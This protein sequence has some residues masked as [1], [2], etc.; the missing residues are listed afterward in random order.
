MKEILITSS[1]LIGVLMLLRLMFAQKVSRKLIYGAWILVALRLLIPVQI[2][3]LDFSVLTA[4]RPLTE[5]V[6]EVSGLRVMG[7]NEREA[8][9]Q[10]TKDYIEQDRTVF[11]PEVQEYIE[12]AIEKNE[13]PEQIATA[14]IKTQGREEI[15][16]EHVQAQVALQVQEQTDFVSLGQAA[17]ILWL[18]GLGVMTL[19]F[20]VV[21]LRHSRNLRK[22]RNKLETDSPIPVY[23]SDAASSPCLVG[24]VRPAVYL[25]PASVAD[26]KMLEHV[27]KHELTHYRHGDHIWAL[28]RGL[29]L[30]IYWFDPLVWAAAY[31]SRRDCELACDEG[32]MRGMDAAERVSYGKTL[33]EV[34]SQ[35]AGPV[36][37][38]QTA[39]SMN[40]N[41]KQLK[42][43]VCFIVKKPKLSITA[44]VCMV[45]L[46]AIVAGCAAA[47]ASA[48]QPPQN[49]TTTTPTAPTS[50]TN[51]DQPSTRIKLNKQMNVWY[52]SPDAHLQCH[53]LVCKDSF[54]LG[55]TI[56]LTLHIK[57]LGKAIAYTGAL[58]DQIGSI[59]LWA[60]NGE[61]VIQAD[62][63]PNTDDV[64]PQEF[65]HNE[66]A[67]LVYQ[68][69]VPDSAQ[70]DSYTLEITAFGQQIRFDREALVEKRYIPRVADLSEEAQRIIAREEYDA[71]SF[72]KRSNTTPVYGEFGDVYVAFWHFTPYGHE[73]SST[74]EEVNGLTFEYINECHIEVYA[75]GG[76]YSLTEA[77]ASGLL[78]TEQIRQVYDNY[79]RVGPQLPD[80][81]PYIKVRAWQAISVLG[82]KRLHFYI[83]G[84]SH[85]EFYVGD[86][87]SFKVIVTNQD[88]KTSIESITDSVSKTAWLVTDQS[89][90][91]IETDSWTMVNSGPNGEYLLPG[92]SIEMLITFTVPEDIQKD[93]RYNLKILVDDTELLFDEY[94]TIFTETD[95]I[96]AGKYG[97]ILG[98]LP[99]DEARFIQSYHPHIPEF[100]GHM[101]MFEYYSYS[102][103]H[104]EPYNI[105]IYLYP[106]GNADETPIAETVCGKEFIYPPGYRIYVVSEKHGCFTLTEAVEAGIVSIIEIRPVHE[107][108][109]TR[110]KHFVIP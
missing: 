21:N 110:Q 75:P 44:A 105:Y 43:R 103:M 81:T 29:C 1:V 15:Y 82:Q 51:A 89:N 66:E 32:A 3:Q 71:P 46:C 95:T 65:R 55:E 64:T 12:S 17:K 7:Q 13:T 72:T 2:G 39:T 99:E 47:G 97:G 19:W 22:N 45:L 83:E 8:D 73:F 90:H 107:M 88:K 37:L 38:L 109:T 50:S 4:A 76:V 59:Q 28:V 104:E 18:C 58:E 14:I 68:F 6:E 24:L 93:H 10:V 53:Y 5:T 49:P 42:E 94:K 78:N 9:I 35:A 102:Y 27:V 33:L 91:K 108:Y 25:T 41:G 23:V 26:P 57:N 60:D 67:T 20:A 87:I 54:Q 70:E 69:V 40:E 80:N 63:K 36:K 30:C 11:V 56:S 101:P 48:T 106:T 86:E 52:N 34:V 96:L 85:K 84:D 79:V 100:Q 16:V 77:F 62:T 31:L 98:G 92:E 74:T 61:Y